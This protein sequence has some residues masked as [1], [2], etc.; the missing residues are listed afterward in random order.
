M[1][2][3]EFTHFDRKF[4]KY[5]IPHRQSFLKRGPKDMSIKEAA[6]AVAAMTSAMTHQGLGPTHL[7]FDIT[8]QLDGGAIQRYSF[9]DLPI[10]VQ[11][12]V[13]SFHELISNDIM[14]DAAPSDT[15]MDLLNK[16]EQEGGGGTSLA[17]A[18]SEA[19]QTEQA[20]PPPEAGMDEPHSTAAEQ[21]APVVIRQQEEADIVPE[22]FEEPDDLDDFPGL[23]SQAPSQP[24]AAPEE[25]HADIFGG[26]SQV[27]STANA[28]PPLTA[29]SGPATSVQSL[30]DYLSGSELDAAEAANYSFQAVAERLGINTKPTTPLE[31]KKLS[32]YQLWYEE[33]ALGQVG[34]ALRKAAKDAEL[35]LHDELQKTYQE[36]AQESIGTLAEKA[37]VPLKEKYESNQDNAWNVYVNDG[38]KAF[39]REKAAIEAEKQRKIAEA[40]AAA[41]AE[42]ERLQNEAAQRVEAD[43]RA[44]EA[45][46]T[47]KKEQYLAEQRQ[48][49]IAELTEKRNDA[50]LTTKSEALL[51]QQKQ[52]AETVVAERDKVAPILLKGQRELKRESM[53]WEENFKRD[54]RREAQQQRQFELLE[55]RNEAKRQ[56][57][58]A[59]SKLAEAKVQAAI[60]C[61]QPAEAVAAIAPEAGHGGQ[62]NVVPLAEAA[63]GPVD[64]VD[65]E[66]ED[67][68]AAAEKERWQ[69]IGGGVAAGVLLCSLG[70]GAGYAMKPT[71]T[72]SN[73]NAALSSK[74]T[75]KTTSKAGLEPET[76]KATVS[77]A[78]KKTLQDL[79]NDKSYLDAAEAYP[80]KESLA[81]IENAIYR[82][83][84]IP[85]L[86]SFNTKYPSNLGKLDEAILRGQGEDVINIYHGLSNEDSAQLDRTQLNAVKLALMERGN[87]EEAVQI[88]GKG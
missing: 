51:A 53:E 9:E 16:V 47:A 5:L 3:V 15:A 74:T 4:K 37:I 18:A 54:A 67:Q 38:H 72:V 79:L 34:D 56:Q 20:P 29:P 86:A 17:T 2:R 57:A 85:A 65:P 31:E 82:N 7:S 70:F 87:M 8:E 61:A 73:Q 55:Q 71:P 83:G 88:F 44:H 45:E 66:E 80:G 35:A 76:V 36:T 12:Y 78:G 33:N 30:H 60:L 81:K 58:A 13:P 23:S 77:S 21:S 6:E 64:P 19:P 28:Q 25:E 84:D 46:L 48:R 26:T 41:I 68:A 50:L 52:L 22:S 14:Q 49:L 24:Q 62:S 40:T 27:R 75:K 63:D 1:L 32:W 59:L 43:R 10:N 69:R 42:A 11:E 39:E